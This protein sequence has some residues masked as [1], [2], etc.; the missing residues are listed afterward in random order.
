MPLRSKDKRITLTD[1]GKLLNLTPRAVSQALNG[2]DSTVRVS[3]ATKK[4]VQTLA[5]R[6]NYRPNRMAQTLRTGKSGMVGVLAFQAF[7]HLFQQKLYL[8]RQYAESHGFHPNIYI[9]PDGSEKS[10][11]RAVDV[12]MDSKVDAVIV[13]NDLGNPQVSQLT[14]AGIPVVVV[15]AARV[16]NAPT[17]RADLKGGFSL[18]AK[19]LIAQGNSNLMFL[20]I[21]ENKGNSLPWSTKCAMEGIQEAVDIAIREGQP[22]TSK[23][24]AL[25]VSY[26]GFM[27]KEAP[28]IHGLH[29]GGYLG[30]KDIIRQQVVPEALIC[31]GDHVVLGAMRACA[32][33]GVIIP[34]D[35]S[36]C[37]LGDAPFSSA[38]FLTI[39]SVRQPLDELCRL[40]F[41]DL[42][43]M[44]E[45]G[46]LLKDRRVVLPYEL[47]VRE[48]T[49]QT[50]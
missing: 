2:E 38:G 12:M 21:V 48:S 3:K 36:I 14:K 24:H 34:K 10:R 7:G 11:N 17:Y 32:E 37:G 1:L 19:H 27:L 43:L 22:V 39:T 8:A 16:R 47:I 30:M 46:K 40:A 26:D 6:L 28:S 33:S 35:M 13:F 9:I 5:R 41:D 29:A 23:T 42:K 25:N 45:S 4:R 31:N 15:G 50:R 20:D 49:L 44:T 18:L